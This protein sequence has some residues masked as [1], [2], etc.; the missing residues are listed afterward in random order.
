MDDIERMK[1]VDGYG[2][3]EEV[4]AVDGVVVV[5]VPPASPDKTQNTTTLESRKWAWRDGEQRLGAALEA[6]QE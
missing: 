5:V 1:R 2:C 6:R 4:F 3:R